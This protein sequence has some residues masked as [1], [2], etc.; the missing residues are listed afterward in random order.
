MRAG[1][2]QNRQKGRFRGHFEQSERLDIAR[3][4]DG[5]GADNGQISA[6]NLAG[7]VFSATLGAGVVGQFR[8]AGGQA[9]DQD[10][11][12]PGRL[13]RLGDSPRALDIGPIE[14]GAVARL[15]QT[16][17]VNNRLGALA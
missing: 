15:D 4:I 12:R 11:S 16:G 2:V 17:H 7:C 14:G 9:G 13:G 5:R 8:L 1:R 3:T 6:K 10:E